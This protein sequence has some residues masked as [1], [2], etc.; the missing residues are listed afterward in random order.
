MPTDKKYLVT[1]LG[2]GPSRHQ[3][4]CNVNVFTWSRVS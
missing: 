2:V 3:T 1:L 4:A